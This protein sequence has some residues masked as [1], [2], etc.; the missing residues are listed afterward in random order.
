LTV[1]LPVPDAPL[2]TV[3]HEEALLVAVHV[4]LA[5]ELVTLTLPLA[6]PA[7]GLALAGE[8]LYVQPFA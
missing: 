8:M 2:V 7:A 5:L 4:Q 3:I 6:P 1:P